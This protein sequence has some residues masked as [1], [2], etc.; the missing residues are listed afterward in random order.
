MDRFELQSHMD[1]GFELQARGHWT[2]ETHPIK[3]ETLLFPLSRV[4]MARRRRAI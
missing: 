2:S 3:L 1:H 4:T